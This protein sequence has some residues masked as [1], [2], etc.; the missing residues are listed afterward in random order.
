MKGKDYIVNRLKERSTWAG[1]VCLLTTF[2]L[3]FAPEQRDAIIG[4]GVALAG[5]AAVFLKDKG[6]PDA[7]PKK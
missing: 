5:L 1:L 6:A 2:G 3:G 7:K 4:A